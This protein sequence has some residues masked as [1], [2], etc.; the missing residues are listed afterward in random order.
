MNTSKFREAA[1]KVSAVAST[2]DT[3][4]TRDMVEALDRR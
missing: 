2:L 3:L 1:I 4:S